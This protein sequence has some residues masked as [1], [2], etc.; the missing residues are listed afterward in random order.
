RGTFIARQPEP[1]AASAPQAAG[2]LPWSSLLS[3]AATSESMTRS[4]RLPQLIGGIDVV[5]LSKMQPSPDLLPDELLRRCF[6][7]RLRTHGPR[8]LSYAAREGAPR[9]RAAIAADL[10]RLGVP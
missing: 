8:T 4:E 1:R 9:L 6:Q 7:H 2:R 5:N 3:R 10:A